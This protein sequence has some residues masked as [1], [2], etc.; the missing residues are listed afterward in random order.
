LPVMLPC[1]ALPKSAHSEALRPTPC[2]TTTTAICW[3][4][5]WM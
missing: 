4:K 1:Q 3:S 5:Q 2:V